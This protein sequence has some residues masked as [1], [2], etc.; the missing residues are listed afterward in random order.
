M[1]LRANH[2][3]YN[4]ESI[5]KLYNAEKNGKI[6]ERLLIIKL[7]YQGRTIEDLVEIFEKSRQT[8]ADR[9]VKFN[10]NGIEGLKTKDRP[11]RPR[12]L[13]NDQTEDLKKK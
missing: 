7:S 9:I 10:Y 13:S 11:G 8:I 3:K 2:P 5:L 12:I 1:V 4:A 6:K